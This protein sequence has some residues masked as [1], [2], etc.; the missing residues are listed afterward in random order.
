ME[1]ERAENVL[2]VCH[3]AVARCILAYFLN[4]DAGRYIHVRVTLSTCIMKMSFIDDC[5]FLFF[6]S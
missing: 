6:L 1:L 2:V 5:N 4:K 3:Q